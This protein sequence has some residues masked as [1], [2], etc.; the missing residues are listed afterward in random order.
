[1]G[2]TVT[3]ISPVRRLTTRARV[4]A[5]L[6]VNVTTWDPIFD[7]LIDEAS[8]AIVRYCNR[9]FAREVYSESLGGTG[10][11]HLML[12]RT[13][14]ITVSSVT[15][16]LTPITDYAIE[17]ADEG[18][19]Y[20]RL[21]W[22]DTRQRYIGIG[23]RGKWMDWG[24]PIQGESEP[25]YVVAYT[26]GYLLP[27]QNIIDS[28]TVSA[29]NADNSF[30]DSASRFPATLKAGDVI[31]SRDFSN[32]ANNGRWVVSGTPT[33][34]K[35]IVSGTLTTEAAGAARSIIFQTLPT[36][37]EKAAIEAVK[38]W[39]A[40]RQDDAN[41]V[42][43]QVG[44]MRVRYAEDSGRAFLPATCVGLLRSWQRAA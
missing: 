3:S 43:K 1:M 18:L 40:G 25:L 20:R 6:G 11:I 34:S 21:G 37:V 12:R 17:E 7:G 14:I 22:V 32:A 42:E 30:N 5:E 38:A 28:V 23:A 44:P 39:Y 10:L 13:P 16:D 8:D 26:A 9:P 15:F 36:D 4:K 29:A 2:L 33:A 41:V 27:E 19:L 24:Q 31:E 35:V